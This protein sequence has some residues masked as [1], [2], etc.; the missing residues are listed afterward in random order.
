MGIRSTG[1]GNDIPGSRRQ[2]VIG[3]F[4]QGGESSARTLATARSVVPGF[5]LAASAADG[6]DERRLGFCLVSPD[7]PLLSHARLP[8]GSLMV[9]DGRFM[10]DRYPVERVLK[11]WVR[12]GTSTF[13]TH[14]FQG[15]VAAWN[16]TTSIGVLLRDPYGFA[17][18]FV[19]KAEDGIVFSTDIA[20]LLHV[21]IDPSPDEIAMDAFMVSGHFPAPMTP[22]KAITKIPPGHQVVISPEGMTNAQAWFDHGQPQQVSKDEASELVGIRMRDALERTWPGSGNAGMLLSGGVDSAMILTGIVRMLD[23]PVSAFTFRYEDYQGK[24]NE[25]GHARAVADHLGVPHEEISI[26]P[27][28]ILDDLGGAVADYGE[29][30]NWGLHSYRLGPIADSGATSLF[31]GVGADGSGLTKRHS[32]AM[33]FSQLPGPIRSMV[34]AAVVAA[35]PLNLR[36]QSKS[37]WA[38]ES[39]SEL[40]GLFT[41][42]SDW[43]RRQRRDLYRDP[44]IVERSAGQLLEIYRVAVEEFQPND[45]ERILL[46]LDKRFTTAEG[47]LAWNRGWTLAH[48]LDLRL[49]YYD[50]DFVDLAMGV[51]GTS[52]GKDVLRQLAS[53]YLPREMAYAPKTPQ[54]MPVNDWIRGPL[55]ESVR[56]RLADPP[57]AMSSMFDPAGMR[58]LVDQ[59]VAG[60]IDY[61]WKL[62]SLLTIAEWFD[63]LPGRSS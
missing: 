18:G 60:Q 41:N 48:G 59:H 55:A 20:L 61:G 9:I 29:P 24:L 15:F 7:V 17:P 52:T 38:T 56:E 62:I 6:V 5:E 33:R 4:G 19:A 22:V 45:L 1:S 36:S 53:E 34:R 35:R 25:G 42:D 37:E 2:R 39:S 21:G 40:G 26:R 13:H 23:E 47:V 31:S 16:A 10:D 30:F 11:D 27:G 49:P 46:L 54:Q 58:K 28:D 12:N 50:H 44:T 3:Y 14:H 32:A 43:N 51:E 57:A 8:N 63:Q